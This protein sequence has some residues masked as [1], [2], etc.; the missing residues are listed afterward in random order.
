VTYEVATDHTACIL[1][2]WYYAEG[3]E[4][5][6]LPLMSS[7]GDEHMQ[8]HQGIKTV[9]DA[10]SVNDLEKVEEGLLAI[11]QQSD[12]VVDILY[13]LIDELA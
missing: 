3:Q 1:G 13:Q 5:M 4:F 10:K 6:H 8:M 11:D 9:M 7:L 12:K 2:K